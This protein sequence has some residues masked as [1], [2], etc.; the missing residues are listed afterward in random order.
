MNIL[1]LLLDPTRASGHRRGGYAT[2]VREVVGA[3]EA[4]GHRVEVLDSRSP[5]PGVG[6]PAAAGSGVRK[7]KPVREARDRHSPGLF[8][9]LRHTGRDLLYLVHSLRCR[10]LVEKRLAEGGIELVYERF[11][12]MQWAGIQ[13]ARR[14]RVPAILEFNAGVG[15]AIAFHG[16]GLARLAAWIE[17]R[18]LRAADRVITVSGILR[19]QVIALGVPPERVV[20]MHNGVDSERFHPGIDGQPVRTR[21]G[22]GAD[23]VVVGFVGTFA[24]WHGV[25]LLI[26]AALSL[27]TSSPRLRF[28]IVGGRPGEPRFD[29]ARRQVAEAGLDERILMI[30]QVPFS[31]VPTYLAAM[32]IGT[33][34]W[35]TDY[36]SPMKIFEYMAMGRALIA[37]DLEVLREVLVDGDNA[38]LVPR[39]DV[40]AFAL[41]IQRLESDPALRRS[42]GQAARRDAVDRHDWRHHAKLIEELAAAS[43]DARS[44]S[45]PALPHR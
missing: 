5:E 16:L 12:H 45:G 32:D 10:R 6:R 19:R 7:S 29:A 1:F 28:L 35:A 37:P 23:E 3:L 18:T 9:T 2:H 8:G 43:R 26:E 30:G 14:H 17:A 44:E 38:L 34:P 33:I 40:R 39:D 15:E 24:A 42:L 36:G 25:D 31:E 4:A 41:A 22:I 20:A 13:A 11:H 27:A 21:L